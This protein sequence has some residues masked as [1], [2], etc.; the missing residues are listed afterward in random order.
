MGIDVHNKS[1]PAKYS[2]THW[3]SYG[4]NELDNSLLF[5]EMKVRRKKWLS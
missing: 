2:V 3:P 1:I 5:T 4:F